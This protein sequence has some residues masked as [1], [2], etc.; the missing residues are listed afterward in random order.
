MTTI[1]ISDSN[2]NTICSNDVPKESGLIQTV[3]I[4]IQT[5]KLLEIQCLKLL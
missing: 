5:S 3:R 1:T 2:F 4:H